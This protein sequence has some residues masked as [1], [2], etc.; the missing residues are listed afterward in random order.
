MCGLAGITGSTTAAQLESFSASL[1][2]RGPDEHGTIRN[3][4]IGLSHTRLAIIDLKTGTQPIFNEDRS[5]A[6]VFNGEIYN[7][8][9]LRN[10]LRTKHDFTTETDTEVIL[11]LYEDRGLDTPKYL[12][13]DFAFCI[14]DGRDNTCLLARDP[15]GVKPLFYTVSKSGR[16]IFASELR[17]LLRHPEVRDEVDPRALAEYL[18]CLYVAAPRTLLKHISKLQPGEAAVWKDGSL[19][20]WKYWSIPQPEI[21]E[22]K[23]REL[24][25]STLDLLASS[26]K[27]RLMADVPVGA[28]LSG[29]L[30]SSL[31]VA[32][33]SEHLP[34]LHTFSIGYGDIDFDELQ[35]ARMVSKQYATTHH[36]FV[37]HPQAETLIEQ[38]IDATDEPIADSS[39]I[40]T[41]LIAQQTRPYVKVALSGIGGDEMFFGYP[42]YLGARL[43]E[44]IP[45]LLRFPLKTASR[46]WS[47]EPSGRDFGGWIRRFGDGLTDTADTRY[48]RWTTFLDRRTRLRLLNHTNGQ[49]SSVEAEMLELLNSGSGSLLDHIFR[50]DISRYVGSDLLPICD[51]MAMAHSLEVRVPFCDIDLVERMARTPASQR[52]PGLQLKPLLRNMARPYL[53]KNILNRKKQGFMIPIGRWFRGDLRDYVESQLQPGRLP[54]LFDTCAV[55]KLWNE[56][57]SGRINATHT[58]W[59][60]LLFSAWV[61]KCTESRQTKVI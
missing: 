53:P 30:D 11:H 51:T 56:H 18:M 5:C 28:F 58:I 36:E 31:I 14:W 45:R 10:S 20:L 46:L 6:I 8:R 26:V 49:D 24:R 54:E 12:K 1:N 37:I 16:L 17:T 23:E 42:R 3:D 19:R 60:V 29:G 50:Y 43:S 9:E 2:H 48:V 7:Y 41:Y 27:R 44:N 25:E 35:Y 21:G 34:R 38:V 15:L 57:L 47:S 52:F 22:L 55:R 59:A 33:A 32:L 13:G 40:P 39:A 61:R 4:D